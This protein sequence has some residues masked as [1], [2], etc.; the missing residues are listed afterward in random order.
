MKLIKARV[1]DRVK[2]LL[3][4]AATRR[5]EREPVIVREALISYF[6]RRGEMP[7]EPGA[8]EPVTNRVNPEAIK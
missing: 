7:E 5:G 4:I 3:G 6:A 2:T 8:P 1:S